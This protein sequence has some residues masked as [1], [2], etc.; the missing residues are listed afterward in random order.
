MKLFSLLPQRCSV[1]GEAS[2][3]EVCRPC[4][5]RREPRGAAA[6][7][8]CQ[9]CG[10]ALLGE[11]A[12]CADCAA[13]EWPFAALDG[14]YGYQEPGAELVRLYKFGGAASLAAGWAS[15]AAARLDP[16]GPLVPVPAL[17]RRR[18]RRGWDPVERWTR[19]LGRELGQPVLRLLARRPSA[20]QKS[21]DREARSSNAAQAYRLIGRRIDCPVVWLVDDIVTT[22][23]TAEACARLLRDAGAREVRVICLG[24]H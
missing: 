6:D 8:R 13:R 23:A 11:H 14:L 24:L 3:D 4:Q 22:G 2:P 21:L 15:A 16:P 19:A 9:I 10:A 12:L 5:A 1:C 17:R 7:T 20:A 18:W